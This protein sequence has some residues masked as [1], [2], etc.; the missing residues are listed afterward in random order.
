M[1]KKLLATAA[2]V[3]CGF[4]VSAHAQASYGDLILGFQASSGTGAS[5]D[6]EID[7]GSATQF[8]NLT[9]G[10]S[11]SIGNINT[12]LTSTYGSWTGDSALQFGVVGTTSKT[13]TFTGNGITLAKSTLFASSAE[14]SGFPAPAY[15]Q[16]AATYYSSAISNIGTLYGLTGATSAVGGS[17]TTNL[18]DLTGH[19]T[20]VGTT[21][22]AFTA[23]VGSSGSGSWSLQ[24]A[25][26]G[27]GFVIPA[28]S[29]VS[30]L[31]LANVG[32]GSAS[33]DLYELAAGSGSA[34]DL[35]YFTLD[36]AGNLSFDNAQT[37]VP[38]PATYAVIIGALAA[39]Y[40]MV[41][42]RL[43]VEGSATPA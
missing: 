11:Y 6:L 35:G 41:R 17:A 3:L 22:T 40:A 7:L 12:D 27:A 30:L 24:E 1:N 20:A 2:A 18:S 42:R 16:K 38:E 15:T 8:M 10:Q 43:G 4:A 23:P 5:T 36:S 29:G 25:A 31:T 26:G 21:L 39:G 28:T 9:A 19:T 13:A 14:S 32:S 37:P 33:T 34:T